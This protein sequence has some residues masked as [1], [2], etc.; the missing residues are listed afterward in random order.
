ML[1][2]LQ[3]LLTPNNEM[4]NT[5]PITSTASE[6]SIQDNFNAGTD[7]HLNAQG[8]VAKGSEMDSFEVLKRSFS[9]MKY[10][11][12]ELKKNIGSNDAKSRLAI[13]S[14]ELQVLVK[15]IPQLSNKSDEEKKERRDIQ[16]QFKILIEEV[17]ELVDEL[18]RNKNAD[19]D[20]DENY[21]K[22]PQSLQGYL[23]KLGEQGLVK[24]WKARYFKQAGKKL[25]YMVSK[26]KLDQLGNPNYKISKFFLIF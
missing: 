18:E 25:I 13:I 6:S 15:M 2:A 7:L 20:E 10:E 9:Q 17:K 26:E 24:K 8:L 4:N 23:K 11:L 19:T 5:L 3:S 12:R 14:T 22:H 16:G 21:L 1:E